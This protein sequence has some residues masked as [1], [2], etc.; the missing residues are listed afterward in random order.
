MKHK[1][2]LVNTLR[3][4]YIFQCEFC[5]NVYR[6]ER[7]RLH[8]LMTTGNQFDHIPVRL[9]PIAGMCTKRPLGTAEVIE[10]GP[11]GLVV[12]VTPTKEAE[13]FFNDVVKRDEE[14]TSRL[15]EALGKV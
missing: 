11:N 6:C 10:D 4:T 15:A 7:G 14:Y 1:L 5:H 9:N 3:W 13:H 12:R 2:K 8:L